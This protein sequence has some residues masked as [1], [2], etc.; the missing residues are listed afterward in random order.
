MKEGK[1][2][3]T[4]QE[5]VFLI[6]VQNFAQ[7]VEKISNNL[8]KI[9]KEAIVGHKEKMQQNLHDTVNIERDSGIWKGMKLTENENKNLIS[10]GQY[11]P[12]L[13]KYPTNETIT[14]RKEKY[15]F[16]EYSPKTDQ[17]SCFACC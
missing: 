17:A 2:H 13:E 12:C 11:Q 6:T 16:L 10:K 1:A 15:P 7:S 3:C 4:P 14:K 8:G 5:E 9:A